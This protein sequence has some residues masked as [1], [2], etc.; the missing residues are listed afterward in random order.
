MEKTN[1]YLFVYG[2]LLDPSNQHALFL[3]M[4]CSFFGDARFRGKLYDT[5]EYPG[6]LY[7]P[8]SKAFVNGKVFKMD[9]AGTV[10]PVLD[11][12]EGFGDNELQPNEFIRMLIDVETESGLLQCWMYVY[13]WPVE[14]MKFICTG[15]YLQYL[16]R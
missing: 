12:Y 9:D 5:G 6:A 16:G 13:N 14:G 7:E 2:S 11:E 4:H 10:L 8:G 1:S 15:N 3:K